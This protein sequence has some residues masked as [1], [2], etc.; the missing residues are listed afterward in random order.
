MPPLE[1]FDR[2]FESTD[3]GR[4]ILLPFST[5]MSQTVDLYAEGNTGPGGSKESASSIAVEPQ[6]RRVQMHAPCR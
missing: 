1:N 6:M 4:G 2:S 3:M 5:M